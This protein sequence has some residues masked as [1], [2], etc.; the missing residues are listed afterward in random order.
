MKLS[1]EERQG[2]SPAEIA[3]LEG[4]GADE[5]LATMGDDKPAPRAAAPAAAPADEAADEHDDGQGNDDD[6]NQAAANADGEHA[7]ADA[8]ALTAEQLAAIAEDTTAAAEPA[9]LPTFDVPER[10]FNAERKALRD[11]RKAIQAK[12]D[13]GDLSDEALQAQLDEVDDKLEALAAER[14][15]ADT[16]RSI[17]EQAAKDAQAKIDAEFNAATAAIIKAASTSTTAKVD[18]IADK[19]AQ[20]QFDMALDMLQADP[21]NAGKTPTQLVREAHRAVLVVRGLPVGDAKPTPT[22]TP[23]TPRP[24]DVPLTLG[25]LPNA[26]QVPVEDETLAQAT[27]LSGDELEAYMARLSPAQQKK[28]M[29]TVDKMGMH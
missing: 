18:Y 19:A 27:R 13:E 22:P 5:A 4:E 1:P 3:A 26:S 29:A 24:R 25:G 10:D 14:A 6:G 15:R 16:L 7:A 17:N 9:K 12:W 20:R 11:S 28:L 8:G 2:L 21:D 23:N